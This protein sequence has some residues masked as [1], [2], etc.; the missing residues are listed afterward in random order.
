[1][2]E[3][4][5]GMKAWASAPTVS[6]EDDFRI[7]EAPAGLVSRVTVE[8]GPR[9]AYIDYPGTPMRLA[10]DGTQAW[11]ESWNVPY[12]PRFLA[13]L[14]YHFLNLPWLASDPG[15]VLSEFGQRTLPGDTTEYFSMKITYEPGTGDTPRD[16]YRLYVH[17]ES[18]LLKAVDYIVTYKAILPEGV[19]ESPPN[20]LVY[21]DFT[22]VNGLKVPTRYTIYQADGTVYATAD[23]REWSFEQPFDEGR[24]SMPAGATLDTSA[25]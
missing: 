4:H 3:A 21:G 7:G 2:T 24:M 11:S 9:R 16:Y 25:P 20:T 8:Q 1:M 18:H 17:P 5:G 13:L 10:W 12:P 6:W 14:N 15:V 23:I 19:T 22:E